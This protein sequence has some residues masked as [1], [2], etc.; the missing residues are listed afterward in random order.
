MKKPEEE[1]AAQR[2]QLRQMICEKRVLG[3]FEPAACRYG[4]TG[5]EPNREQWCPVCLAIERMDA[6]KR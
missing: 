3:A 2:Y 4:G 1:I 6:E 5:G